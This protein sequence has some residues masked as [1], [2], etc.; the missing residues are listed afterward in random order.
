MDLPFQEW[1]NSCLQEITSSVSQAL[2]LELSYTVSELFPSKIL[3]RPTELRKRQPVIS[4][5]QNGDILWAKQVLERNSRHYTYPQEREE[6]MVEA[7]L[8]SNEE[9]ADAIMRG[10]ILETEEYSFLW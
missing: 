4:F 6:Q 1:V 3:R 9:Q 5:S 8:S 7:I 2:S 10:V